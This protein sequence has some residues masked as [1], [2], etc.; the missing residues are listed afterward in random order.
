MES[1]DSAQRRVK[2]RSLVGFVRMRNIDIERDY[3]EISSNERHFVRFFEADNMNRSQYDNVPLYD[4]DAVRLLP[5]SGSSDFVH[6]SKIITSGGEGGSYI[7]AQ[8]PLV[9]PSRPR[10]DT[11]YNWMRM[12]WEF[13]V[14]VA[15]CLVNLGHESECD[16]Y[17]NRS[18]GET[19]KVNNF[20][21]TT[22]DVGTDVNWCWTYYR[23]KISRKEGK[24]RYE[25]VI[26]LVV[27]RN[28]TDDPRS[29]PMNYR[30]L[31][32]LLHFVW[33]LENDSASQRRAQHGSVGERSLLHPTLV[34][35]RAGM[36]RAGTYV[37][38][39]IFGRH[40]SGKQTKT[41]SLKRVVKVC[42]SLRS[43]RYDILNRR[44]QF[45]LLLE[46]IMEV[47]VRNGIVNEKDVGRA[48]DILRRARDE[49]GKARAKGGP[50]R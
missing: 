47:A 4:K 16:Y 12:L 13:N 48:R 37:A 9:N 38:A 15:V 29:S 30:D 17:F 32:D 5:C 23:L 49:I 28:W 45:L 24:K 1:D 18:K 21:I 14:Y 22:L 50:S 7:I 31:S 26:Q 34:H 19:H 33:S 27:C 3:S 46:T 36:N 6:A 42:K 41:M 35:S 25:R 43:A 20:E 40:L 44:S 2:G 11:Q 39:S 10:I 8:T